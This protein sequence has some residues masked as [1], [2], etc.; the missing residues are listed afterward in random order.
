MEVTPFTFVNSINKGLTGKNLLKDCKADT[1]LEAADPNSP[2]KKYLPFIINKGLSQF[3]DTIL[4][5]NEMN[6]R[7]HLPNKMQFDFLR[8][9]IRPGKRFSKWSKK[10]KDPE[11]LKLI[12]EAYSYSKEK[13]EQVLDI[14]DMNHVRSKTDKGG[15]QKR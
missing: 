13:A 14:V 7:S 6:Q 11:D 2:D 3:K 8:H 1:S 10:G 9:S 15:F 5:A 12:Q 4:F